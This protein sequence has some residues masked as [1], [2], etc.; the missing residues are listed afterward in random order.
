MSSTQNDQQLHSIPPPSD[1]G[2]N[3]PAR[4]MSVNDSDH[5]P[6]EGEFEGMH[7]TIWNSV[8]LPDPTQHPQI[9]CNFKKKSQCMVVKKGKQVM[10]TN[11]KYLYTCA[12]CDKSIHMDC[13][14]AF[15]TDNDL[16][17][18]VKEMK[19]RLVC[20]KRCYQKAKKD[21]FTVAALTKKNRVTE[22][23]KFWDND[24]DPSSQEILLDWITDEQNADKYFGAEES[25]SKNGF[26]IED[27]ISK[28]GLCKQISE[29]ILETNGNDR[30]ADSVRS[31]IDDL[32]SRF[33]ATSDWVFATG[34]GVRETEGEENFKQI[35]RDKFKYYYELE[36]IL[37]QRP[38]I[39]PAFTT[40]DDVINMSQSNGDDECIEFD[41]QSD[42]DLSVSTSGGATKRKASSAKKSYSEVK[43][44]N[45]ISSRSSGS[46]GNATFQFGTPESMETY[47][48]TKT[49]HYSARTDLEKN[50]IDVER[51]KLDVEHKKMDF[52]RR[53]LELEEK[54]FNFESTLTVATNNMKISK[55]REE[56]ANQNPHMSR[57]EIAELFPFCRLG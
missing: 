52:D 22:N 23:P 34:Q 42:L 39:R 11:D 49:A 13:Y 40:D 15:V 16:T 53:R 9:E 37:S 4:D 18:I 56:F 29:L 20:G 44:I 6:S 7:F 38:S 28:L 31:K 45:K 48:S 24:G 41:T 1:K 3:A 55:M 19:I 33:K 17:H 57:E 36:P 46:S 27:G 47:L 8:V 2:I 25:S 35:V 21:L 32:V 10:S 51:N 5:D 43:K 12:S 54:R 26:A 50:K 14:K 30:S